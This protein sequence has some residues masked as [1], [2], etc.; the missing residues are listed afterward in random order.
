MPEVR[1]GVEEEVGG[2]DI[3]RSY[4]RPIFA[5]RRE[6]LEELLGDPAWSRRLGE[7]RTLREVQRILLEFAEERGYRVKAVGEEENREEL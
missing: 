5:V 1:G 3:R 2:T 7:A 6:V 4:D